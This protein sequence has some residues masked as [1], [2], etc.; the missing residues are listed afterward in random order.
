MER[1]ADD[2]KKHPSGILPQGRVSS[3]G[4]LTFP[5]RGKPPLPIV[6]YIQDAGDPFVFKPILCPCKHRTS[7]WK[8]VC[9]GMR[10]QMDCGKFKILITAKDCLVCKD[11]EI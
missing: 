10:Q 2:D 1:N 9:G 6:G 3:E 5:H 4:V 8:N 11:S 7:K